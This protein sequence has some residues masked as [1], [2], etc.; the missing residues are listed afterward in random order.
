MPRA[1]Q[2]EVSGLELGERVVLV[3][4]DVWRQMAL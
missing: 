3:V 4:E 1:G 2:A